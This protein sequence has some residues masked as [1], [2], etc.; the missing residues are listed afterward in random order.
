MSASPFNGKTGEVVRYLIG[1]LA[2][3]MVAYFTAQAKTGERLAVVETREQAR[4]EAVQQ[5]MNAI[6]AGQQGML[7]SQYRIEMLFENVI[8]DWARG[9]DRR[10]G[11]PLPLQPAL[12]RNGGK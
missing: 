2:A 7:N 6:E 3:G 5:R 10:T 9:V 4:W 8:R 1:L 11:E 12:E